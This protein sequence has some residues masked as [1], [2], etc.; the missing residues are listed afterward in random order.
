MF[1]RK[2][3]RSVVTRSGPLRSVQ[4]FPLRF[5]STFRSP[6]LADFLS[7]T[8]FP[9]EVVECVDF[10]APSCTPVHASSTAFL[11]RLVYGRKLTDAEIAASL[12]HRKA[13]ARAFE[14]QCD[15]A[16]FYE[17]DTRPDSAR[18]EAFLELLRGVPAEAPV[19]INLCPA[20]TVVTGRRSRARYPFPVVGVERIHTYSTNAQAYVVSRG[21]LALLMRHAADPIVRPPDYPPAITLL[22]Q[23]VTKRGWLVGEETSGTSTVGARGSIS[24]ISR[25]ARWC[26]RLTGVTYLIGRG[27]YGGPSNYWRYEVGQR[28]E[29][30]LWAARAARVS[31]TT[32]CPVASS[33]ES[34]VAS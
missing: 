22:D 21:G 34:Q 6:A 12:S 33:A 2:V 18:L 26:A 32:P 31:D 25:V 8:N 17:D 4:H 27:L 9:V 3:T 28:L 24:M 7:A 16:V 14:S 13:W 30:R 10:Q 19:M 15:W 1:R 11:A 20:Q 23:F 29:H 5:R